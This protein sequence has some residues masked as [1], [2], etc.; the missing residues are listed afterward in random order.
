MIENI[1]DK[2]EKVLID[3]IKNMKK[4]VIHGDVNEQNIVL[5]SENGKLK[6]TGLLDFSDAHRAPA[7]FDLAIF[8]CYMTIMDS[9]EMDP[10]T[11]PGIAI[12]GYSSIIEIS[13]EE[14]SILPVS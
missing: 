2:L 11:V 1:F 6:V 8:C 10:L 4:Q 12:A 3:K 5:Q 7:I 13:E 9:I 14:W